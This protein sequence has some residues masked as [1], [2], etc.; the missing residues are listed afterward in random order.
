MNPLILDARVKNLSKTEFE[1]LID[2]PVILEGENAYVRFGKFVNT[3]HG[4]G[5][6]KFS[7]L[8]YNLEK[9]AQPTGVLKPSDNPGDPSGPRFWFAEPGFYPN[10]GGVTITGAAGVIV[11]NGVSYSAGNFN[12]ELVEYAKVEEFDI[13]ADKDA[14]LSSSKNLF[15]PELYDTEN[16]IDNTGVVT[17]NPGGPPWLGMYTFS[18]NGVVEYTLSN[19]S[20]NDSVRL[21]MYDVNETLISIIETSLPYTFSTTLST[22]KVRFMTVLAKNVKSDRIQLEK[23]NSVTSF[24]RYS[25]QLKTGLLTDAIRLADSFAQSENLFDKNKYDKFHV[26]DTATGALT[27]T[28]EGSNIGVFTIKEIKGRTSYVLSNPSQINGMKGC[29]VL[30]YDI[31]DNLVLVTSYPDDE[32]VIFTTNPLTVTIRVNTLN[33]NSI[34]KDRMMFKEGTTVTTSLPFYNGALKS[35]I[36]LQKKFAEYGSLKTIVEADKKF[37]GVMPSGFINNLTDSTTTA[38]G[39]NIVG[40]GN[41]NRRLFLDKYSHSRE[42]FV[43]ADFKLNSGGVIE[44][45]LAGD[46]FDTVIDKINHIGYNTCWDARFYRDGGA[47]NGKLAI[48]YTT[49]YDGR[50]QKEI[51]TT[52]IVAADF[53]HVRI[54]L[55]HFYDRYFAT[56]EVIGDPSRKISIGYQLPTDNSSNG[57]IIQA[58]GARTSV[59]I[60]SGNVTLTDFRMSNLADKRNISTVFLGDSISSAFNANG[61]QNAYQFIASGGDYSKFTTLSGPGYTTIQMIYYVSELLEINPR[62]VYLFPGTNDVLHGRTPQELSDD[63]EYLIVLCLQKG[64]LPVIGTLPRINGVENTAHND[65]TRALGAKYGLKIVENEGLLLDDDIAPDDV[66]HNPSGHAKHGNNIR[67]NAP[68]LF[69]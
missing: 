68:E 40:G 10:A 21:A 66:H 2:D 3:K 16:I 14:L 56:A 65:K 8:E 39:L 18:V 25:N 15:N 31:E 23:G 7:E 34:F 9:P 1:W 28:V 13:K 54:T 46:D 27:P 17:A 58:I 12:I 43:Q 29:Y 60:P 55:T 42:V 47:D 69:L 41:H 59:F 38:S 62:N 44:V 22:R 20:A 64:I 24:V 50:V 5:I 37:I 36:L 32:A 52:S 67:V 26:A 35:S 51:S 6:S 30:E 53:E 4:D 48:I 63:I 57:S 61:Y 11:D 49:L 45:G 19:Q 33:S